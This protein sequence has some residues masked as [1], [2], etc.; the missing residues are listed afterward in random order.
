MNYQDIVNQLQGLGIA[1]EGTAFSSLGNIT[2]EQIVQGLASTYNVAGLEAGMFPTMSPQL[3][4]GTKASTY[5]PFIQSQ[6]QDLL[7][8]LALSLGGQKAKQAAGGFA[9]SGGAQSYA[10]GVKDVYGKGMSDVLSNIGQQRSTAFGELQNMIN[11]YKKTAQEF[12]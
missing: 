9:G 12:A 4:R 6:S 5:S 1:G 10:A 7:S 11:Q 3:L 2:P 8:N